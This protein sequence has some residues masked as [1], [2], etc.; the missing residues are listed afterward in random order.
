MHTA[1]WCADVA[2]RGGRCTLSSRSSSCYDTIQ[3]DGCRELGAGL[4]S[5][6]SRGIQRAETV[7]QDARRTATHLALGLLNFHK[8]GAVFEDPHIT[9]GFRNDNGNSLG[10][11][12]NAS[13]CHVA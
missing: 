8:D 1:D 6:A 13:R 11:R 9:G 4:H 3:R 2:A 10:H 7:A 12:G 5:L